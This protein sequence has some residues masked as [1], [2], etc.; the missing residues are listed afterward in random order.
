[1]K[2]FNNS[3][4]L[5]LPKL[6]T[7]ADTRYLLPPPAPKHTFSVYAAMCAH[8]GVSPKV[9]KNIKLLEA[10]PDPKIHF[11]LLDG[12]ALIDRS[13]GRV[14]TDFLLNSKDDYL[15]FLDDDILFDPLDIRQ[16]LF[17]AH[18]N[19]LDIAGA[20]YPTKSETNSSFT[21]RALT[22]EEDIPFGKAGGICEVRM[23]A[24]GCMAI[25]RRVFEKMAEKSVVHLCHTQGIKFFPFFT[26][27]EKEI[28][29]E[30][31]Y[32][33]EDWAFCERARDLGF[34]VWL[35]TT[36]RLGHIGPKV[37]DW[38]DMLREPKTRNDGFDLKI[39]IT[40]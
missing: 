5:R 15:L 13:R 20:A 30:W 14:A 17:A 1:M 4:A 39:R 22:N 26:P 40:K 2:N 6:S 37:Y 23:Q 18:K 7:S 36:I 11:E 34:K 8:R 19:D 3:K 25:H 35:D 29:G 27:M 10:C 16:L 21:F 12:D 28:D 38:D 33:S 9:I 32:L 31:M 24:T